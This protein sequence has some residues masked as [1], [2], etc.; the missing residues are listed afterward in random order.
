MRLDEFLTSHGVSYTRMPHR[1][2]YTAN[3]VAQTLH[4]RGQEMAKTVLV[5]TDHGHVLA[6]L[7]A[8]HRVD[9]ERLRQD[10]HEEH[11]G[12]ATEGEMEQLF[13]DCERGAMPPF[14]SLYQLPTVVDESLAADEEI[15]FEGQN[16]EEAIRMTYRDYATL[17]HPR[18]GHFACRS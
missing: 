9:L 14:G 5:R 7:P 3:R 16:H 10:L 2:V 18:V 13:P 12:L 8:T 11:V 17:E 4:V 1:P 15:V 6:V